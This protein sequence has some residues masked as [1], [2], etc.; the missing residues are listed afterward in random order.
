M[1]LYHY[2][3]RAELNVN[4]K[5]VRT[6]SVTNTCIT[7]YMRIISMCQ[8]ISESY[9]FHLYRVSEFSNKRAAKPYYSCEFFP[10]NTFFHIRK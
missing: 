4:I 2:N 3:L 5:N 7:K 10:T 9:D 1:L 8:I 6:I